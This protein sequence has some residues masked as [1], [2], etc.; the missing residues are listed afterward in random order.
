MKS[1][2]AARLMVSVT[3]N[4]PSADVR[5]AENPVPAVAA[6]MSAIRASAASWV[7][8]PPTGTG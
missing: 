6:L 2:P 8:D 3:G 7:V 1:A 4:T 5:T